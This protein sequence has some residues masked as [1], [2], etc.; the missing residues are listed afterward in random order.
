MITIRLVGRSTGVDRRGMLRLARDDAARLDLLDG[1]SVTLDIGKWSGALTVQV[2]DRSESTVTL[3]RRGPVLPA[4]TLA[5]YR[6]GEDRLKLGPLIGILIMYRVTSKGPRGS[7][8]ETYV[9]LMRRSREAGALAFILRAATVERGK[10]TVAGWTYLNGRWVRC[11]LP[12]PDVVYNRICSRPVERR[13]RNRGT[14]LRLQRRGIPVFN[15]H[16]LNKWGVYR[17]LVQDERVRPYLPETRRFRSYTDIAEL[18]ARYGRVFLK[19]AGG[20]LG[21]G[22]MLVTRSRSGGV[23]YKLNTMSGRRKEGMFRQVHSLRRVIPKRNDYLVQRAIDLAKVNGRSFDVRALVQKEIDGEWK[24]TGA[25]ARV[26][27]RGRITTHVPRGGSRRPLVPL[28]NQVFGTGVAPQIL[29]RL[30]DACLSA[31]R[32]Y[33]RLTGKMFGE[34]SLDVAIDG[35][36]SVW[37]LEMN[38]KPFR[39]DE[40]GLRRLAQTR[41]VRFATYLAGCPVEAPEPRVELTVGATGR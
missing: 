36:G 29:E 6:V 4:K 18:L 23:H 2:S 27:G 11:R 35:A 19:P 13:V 25:A 37:I 40:R 38:A 26:A 8:M 31:A 7:Q 9:E 30:E 15:P 5:L 10:S 14:F 16:Y 24:L 20:S 3:P 33:E 22:A 17:T 34:F 12:Y 41:L 39:F 32:G 1:Q 28:L 21:L